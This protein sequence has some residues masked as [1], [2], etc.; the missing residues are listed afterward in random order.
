MAAAGPIRYKLLSENF[1]GVEDG[2][3]SRR[4]KPLKSPEFDFWHAICSRTIHDESWE[5]NWRTV[6]TVT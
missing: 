5:D 4:L 6:A 1:T 3:F 2:T